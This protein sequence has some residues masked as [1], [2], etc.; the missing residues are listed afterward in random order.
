MV[1]SENVVNKNIMLW[2]AARMSFGVVTK[3]LPEHPVYFAWRKDAPQGP[4]T[5]RHGLS[6]HHP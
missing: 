4:Q 2:K 3:R 6:C 5:P 1:Y